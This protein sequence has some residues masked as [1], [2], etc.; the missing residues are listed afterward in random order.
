MK[1]SY[2][3]QEVEGV[4]VYYSPG[5]MLVGPALRLTLGGF[6]KFRWLKVDGVAPAPACSL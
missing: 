3:H 1:K 5:M 6:W 4:T 2:A